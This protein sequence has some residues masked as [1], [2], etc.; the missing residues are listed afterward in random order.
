[1]RE[2][3]ENRTLFHNIARIGVS[4]PVRTLTT[5]WPVSLA[6]KTV[7]GTVFSNLGTVYRTFGGSIYTFQSYDCDGFRVLVVSGY[8]QI[9]ATEPARIDRHDDR[10]ERH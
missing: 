6:S 3:S 9:H 4:V 1:M 10:R 5:T 8:S 7:L 2:D